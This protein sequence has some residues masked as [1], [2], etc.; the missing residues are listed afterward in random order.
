VSPE[1][2]PA[3]HRARAPTV[4]RALILTVSDSRVTATDASGKLIQERL[5]A[6][7]HRVVDRDLVPD[8]PERIRAAVLAAIARPDVDLVLVTGGTGVAPRDTTPDTVEP[9]LD[10]LLAGFGEL[11]RSLSWDEI[12]P[13][14]M[15]SR[16]LAGTAG[17][18]A[19]FVVPGSSA[20]VRL[21]LDRLILPEIGH[22]LEQLRR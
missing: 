19:V 10:K 14:A 1:D 13:A 6:R 22:V 18:T 21:A 17:R 15:L 9:L 16:A 4:V 20:A 5:E 7:G 12:G 11:F 8:E 2:V 3:A